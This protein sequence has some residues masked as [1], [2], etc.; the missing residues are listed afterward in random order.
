MF[1]LIDINIE[2]VLDILFLTF[3]NAIIKFIEKKFI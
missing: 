3:D 2:I 1:L